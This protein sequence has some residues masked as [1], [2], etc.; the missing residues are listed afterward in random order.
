MRAV[1]ASRAWKQVLRTTNDRASLTR[2]SRIL[3]PRRDTTWLR[4]GNED[5]KLREPRVILE[6]R[7]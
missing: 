5:G 2:R 3:G 6:I 7:A 1:A 4:C